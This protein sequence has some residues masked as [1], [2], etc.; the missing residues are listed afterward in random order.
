MAKSSALGFVS[1]KS[2]REF[3]SSDGLHRSIK[4]SLF[5]LDG[6]CEPCFNNFAP[7]SQCVEIIRPPLHQAYPLVP[8]IAARI[9]PAHRVFVL[10]RQRRLDC[11][12]TPLAAF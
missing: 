10:M 5:R 7:L 4:A 12:V 6:A 2:H 8:I 11:V 1:A 3:A 9:G